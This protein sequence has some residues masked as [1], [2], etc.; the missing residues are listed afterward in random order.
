MNKQ[1]F[2]NEE[3]GGNLKLEICPTANCNCG[4]LIVTFNA[5][6]SRPAEFELNIH[7]W[8]FFTDD[9]DE[10]TD[11]FHDILG[12]SLQDDDVRGFFFDRYFEL[13]RE[14][15]AEDPMSTPYRFSDSILA[16]RYAFAFPFDEHFTI[17]C[18][19]TKYPVLDS[20]FENNDIWNC[21]LT[22]VDMESNEE[23]Q[24]VMYHV[25]REEKTLMLVPI[26]GLKA[27][28]T[29]DKL[30]EMIN[31]QIPD[32]WERI[33]K[34]FSK[35]KAAC[36]SYMESDDFDGP[37]CPYSYDDD[38][39]DFDDDDDFEDDDYLAEEME[40]IFG[41]AFAPPQKT[42]PEPPPP[43]FESTISL[44]KKLQPILI[45]LSEG[46]IPLRID[47][48]A[49]IPDRTEISMMQRN[50]DELLTWRTTS[51]R[52]LFRGNA[53]APQLPLSG[54]PPEE[55]EAYFR[56]IESF[57]ADYCHIAGIEPSDNEF[58]EIFSAVRR[59][60]DGKPISDLHNAIWQIAALL[61]GLFPLSQAEFEAIF[62]R[63]EQSARHVKALNFTSS[64]YLHMINNDNNRMYMA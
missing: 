23:L 6:S 20:Y 21:M 50:S 36:E 2:I 8:D 42:M 19:A 12:M 48:T 59:R 41:R 51:L 54:A 34:R 58:M 1:H 44:H 40:D 33:E 60:P 38:F 4:T 10:I 62:L 18:G 22:P 63:L 45:G 56:L 15:A 52:E 25:N 31:A 27:P 7:D 3:A 64:N 55:Y 57:I 17:T 28:F 35:L 37:D 11:Q 16:V 14:Q 29:E 53:Q 32:F 30:L 39:D 24:P 9:E 43:I 47:F 46:N 61:L 5:N 49:Q 26:P 13:K